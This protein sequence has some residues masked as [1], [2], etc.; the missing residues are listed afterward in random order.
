MVEPR[1]Y[2]SVRETDMGVSSSK[3]RGMK[4]TDQ[5]EKSLMNHTK[6]RS[7]SNNWVPPGCLPVLVGTGDEPAE[8]FVIE[9]R[10]LQEPRIQELLDMGTN[11]FGYDLQGLI[12]IHC[13]A[14]QFDRI[15]SEITQSRL[16][17]SVCSL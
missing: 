2:D 7:D 11:K 13:E 3:R 16:R 1:G 6:Y 12:R 10:L 5:M 15:I 9:L 17:R 4:R 14:D 8:R